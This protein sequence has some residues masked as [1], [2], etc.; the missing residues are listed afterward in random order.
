MMATNNLEKLLDQGNS[1]SP[2][3]GEIEALV[4]G[5]LSSSSSIGLSK[6]IELRYKDVNL[7]KNVMVIE[8]NVL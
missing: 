3:L 7:A 2:D 6:E 4:P 8:E 5:L 1:E